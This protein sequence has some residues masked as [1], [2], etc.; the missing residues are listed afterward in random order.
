[1][2]DLFPYQAAG[3]DFLAVRDKAL[4]ADGMGLGKTVQAIRACDEI[5]ATRV[6]V[7]CPAIARI[8]WKRE[9][10]RWG[11]LKGRQLF[12][13]SYDKVA[14]KGEA[15]EAIE[16]MRPDVLILDEAHYLKTRS[17]KRT[18]S[19]YGV[20]TRGDGLAACAKR[21]WLLTGTPAPNDVSELYSHLKA[22]WPEVLPAPGTFD[23]FIRVYTHF[24]AT[25]FGIKILGN[26]N[27]KELRAKLQPVM[28]RRK[29]E[30]VLKDLPPINWHD[31][32]LEADEAITELKR[33]EA[34]P[35]VLM[36]LEA[37]KNDQALP[38][39]V[40]MASVRRMT[41]VAKAPAVSIL[42]AEELRDNAYPKVIVFAHHKD[43]ISLL[44]RGLHEY[45][46]VTI[47]GETPQGARQEAI[48][49]FQSDPT[50]RVFIGQIQACSTAITLTAANQV[51]FAEA[52]WTPSDNAQA[53]KR[54]HRIG[55][56]RPVIV[57]MI[58]LAGSIDEA[59]TRV[60]ARKSRLISELLEQEN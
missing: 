39:S 44:A 55:Q 11:L 9:F 16:K 13:E 1:L 31:L 7:I 33:L 23:A 12:I 56:E 22:L 27:I 43:V 38:D 17:S 37:I 49:R 10:D 59:V 40:A 50:C 41:G 52:S 54:A 47:T 24:D 45:G 14:R 3:R 48:D 57:R 26:K 34:D 30:D 6:A 18:K 5:A 2:A 25:P 32:A 4:L 21:V 8:N 58:G 42:L 15:Y 35:E 20:Y 19:V 51:V 60:L 28:L 46:A 29:A 53:A 36:L